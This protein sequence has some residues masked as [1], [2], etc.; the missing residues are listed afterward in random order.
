M[1]QDMDQAIHYETI[2]VY[3][4]CMLCLARIVKPLLLRDCE[5]ITTNIRDFLNE[6]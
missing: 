6:V 1:Y 4:F 2:K 3:L 5:P